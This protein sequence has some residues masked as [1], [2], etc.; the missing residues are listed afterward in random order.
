M[1]PVVTRFAPS[2]TGRL[3]IGHAFSALFGFNRARDAGGIFI[4]RIEDIDEGRCRPEFEQGIFDDLR[5]LGLSW[6]EPVRRQS[7]YMDDY[8]EA[9][10]KLSDLDLLY[11]CFCTRKDIQDEIARAASAPHGPEGA[12]YP[13]TCRHLT[14]DQRA[15][16]MRAGKSYAFR[17]DT[18]KAAAYL[19]GKN[20]WPLTWFDHAK[21]EQIATPEILGDVV[22]ARKDVSASYHLSVTVDD[23]LQGVTI[24][25]RGE[26]LFYASHLHRLLQEL[27]GLTVPAWHHHPLL[28][29][30]EG[31]RFAKRNNSVT[32][33]HLREAEGKT[34]ADIM[35]MI[36]L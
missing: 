5:W 9:L 3:H 15:D 12:L 8:K 30:H 27:L 25:T 19:R 10:H 29:D 24:V 31:K 28:L 21:G 34:S 32:L 36:G 7:D 22:L 20:K 4:L 17:L 2:P 18:A 33:Q 16:N 23:H 11:P 6:P 13:G 26:D 1:N 35:R 14:D